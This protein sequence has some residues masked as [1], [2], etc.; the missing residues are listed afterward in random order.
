[1]FDDGSA[2]KPIGRTKGERPAPFNW[3]SLPDDL[4]IR[5]MDEIRACLPATSL[6]EMNL[7]EELVLQLHAMRV[8]Q[9]EVLTDRGEGTEGIPLNQITSV[10]NAVSSALNRLV[11]LQNEIYNSERFKSIENLLI[12][13]LTKLPEDVASAFL[14]EYK[15]VLESNG[16]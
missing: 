10:A 1:M 5:Y 16:K 11:E 8:L 6:K 13:T 4:L 3:K 12:R 2:S 14:T 15:L 7:E 9:N